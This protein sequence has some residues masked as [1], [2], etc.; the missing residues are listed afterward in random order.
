VERTGLRVAVML[1]ERGAVVVEPGV[2]AV[3]V[4]T[5]PVDA[6]DTTGAGDAFVG[7]FAYGLG[8]GM[9]ASDAAALGCRC[10]SSSVTRP[11]T[12]SSFPVAGDVGLVG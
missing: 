9:S 5:P 4:S 3:E 10:A 8:S 12:Q 11:G 6:V 2:A 1:G 7:A